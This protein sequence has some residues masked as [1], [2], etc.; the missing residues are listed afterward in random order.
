MS[1]IKQVKV[2][3]WGIY[4]LQRLKH[5]FN[6]T[7]YCDLTLQFQDNAQLK[8]HRL[9]LNACTEYFELLERTCEMYEDC[10]IMPDDLQAEVVV[11]IVNFMYTGQLEF[12]MDL[13]EKLFQTSQ[14]MN[15]P[16]LSKLLD[17]QRIHHH[18][19]VKQTYQPKQSYSR[20]N[21]RPYSKTLES[22][23]SLPVERRNNTTY[24]PAKKIAERMLANA[25]KVDKLSRPTVHSSTLLVPRPERRGT[26]LTK[27][28]L[29][30][31]RPTRYE[32]PEELDSDNIFDNSFMS[33][34]YDS[35]PLMT[36]PETSKSYRTKSSG[37]GLFSEASSSKKM[38][39]P[40]TSLEVECRK[41][42]TNDNFFDEQDNVMDD[43]NYYKKTNAAF[44]KNDPSLLFDQVVD[45][46]T[47]P[48]MLIETKDNKTASNIDHAKIISEVLK[49][50]PHLVN[51]NKN[52]KL[53]ILENPQT[54]AVKK[55]TSKKRELLTS[56]YSWGQPNPIEVTTVKEE[57]MENS[58]EDV[59][60]SK[61]AAQLISMGAENI[62]GP[63]ICLICGTPGKALHFP[64]YYK[65]RRHLVEIHNEKAIPTICEYCGLKSGKRNYLLHHMYS[66][67]GVPPPPSYHF[68]KC[69]LC[70]YIA[71]TEGFLVKHKASHSE[72][73][74]FRCNVCF[75]IFKT[76][77][78]LLRHIQATGHKFTAERK[79]NLQC[80]YCQKVFLRESNL[81]AHLKTS[82]KMEAKRDG[83]VDDSD[84]EPPTNVKFEMPV[85]IYEA[86]DDMNDMQYQIQSRPDGNIQV[87]RSPVTPKQKILNTG[88]K[89][90]KGRPRVPVDEDIMEEDDLQPQNTNLNDE[91]MITEQEYINVN[92]VEQ[93]SVQY[94]MPSMEQV[95][96]AVTLKPAVSYVKASNEQQNVIRQAKIPKKSNTNAAMQFVMTNQQETVN[97]EI[98]VLF[99]SE[100]NPS[101]TLAVLTTLENAHSEDMMILPDNEYTIN[102]PHGDETSQNIVVVY[103][104]SMDSPKPFIVDPL[105]AQSQIITS[106]NSQ[107][108]QAPAVITPT[109]IATPTPQIIQAS[110]Q[111]YQ[112][113]IEHIE[114]VEVAIEQSLMP[115]VLQEQQAAVAP[116]NET[117]NVGGPEQVA[118][119]EFIGVSEVSDQNY[120]TIDGAELQEQRLAESPT[121]TQ[122]NMEDHIPVSGATEG[123]VIILSDNIVQQNEGIGEEVYESETVKDKENE[124][125]EFIESQPE[126]TEKGLHMVEETG[127]EQGVAFDGHEN[128]QVINSEIE[129]SPEAMEIAEEI[130]E[131]EPESIE[132][133]GNIT[134]L[135]Q[136]AEVEVPVQSKK[137]IQSLA[138]EWSEDDEEDSTVKESTT[139][140]KPLLEESIENI[141]DEMDKNVTGGGNMEEETEPEQDHSQ[142]V[143]QEL[144][145]VAVAR[146]V[147]S[148][149]CTQVPQEK[150]S[151]LLNDWDENDSQSQGENEN[152]NYENDES[153]E[154]KLPEE[155]NNGEDPEV[156]HEEDPNKTPLKVVR[157][158]VSDWDEEEEEAKE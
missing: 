139:K 5:F 97:A 144:P 52:I 81:F 15:I 45:S 73:R 50:Y 46:N 152:T 77:S 120:S 66:K 147:S 112:E 78:L 109:Y 80:I 19:Q 88:L 62:K 48:K 40:S 87:T 16:V 54:K 136:P 117:T 138:S 105:Y 132:D 39:S 90:V 30:D 143:L 61:E 141:Q 133:T 24:I 83:I 8:V 79:A 2:D 156:L 10:L 70:N 101:K 107:F 89:E 4:F 3:N 1:D 95:E 126:I 149:G 115:Q 150:I 63:W 35:K 154:T 17:A 106:Q 130:T 11:P 118:E 123:Q 28:E 37:F 58:Y 84:E 23:T 85:P 72:Q 31:P 71:L 99:D 7:D 111:V 38:H 26:H 32:V 102:V 119:K 104:H 65:F 113:N 157:S 6:R 114:N 153:G 148:N 137:Q 20:S 18:K 127:P 75:E 155:G 25:G 51:S 67:H 124:V 103:S 68:P 21:K 86:D 91:M 93:D 59:L 60:N 33:I 134:E 158:L 53:K 82:H 151:S 135:V 42:P 14:I 56:H 140:V 131:N 142:D 74:D 29:A 41:L 64:T 55:P 116:P 125:E 13:V 76:S 92:P 128:D 36:H 43:S 44:I 47:G 57:R 98:P 94:Y 108:V 110:P 12:E 27:A 122:P 146:P 145:V 22:V 129:E 96:P 69:N 121:F 49:K 9:V 34:S 100:G